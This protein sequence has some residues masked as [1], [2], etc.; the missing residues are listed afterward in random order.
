MIRAETG[1]SF[2]DL[3]RRLRLKGERIAAR[4]TNGVSNRMRTRRH[5]WRSAE[6]LWPDL[7]KD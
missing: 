3:I 1:S 4:R 2:G 7:F 5:A 6:R